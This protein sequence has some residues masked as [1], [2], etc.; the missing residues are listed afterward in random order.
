MEQPSGEAEVVLL[1][2]LGTEYY[3]LQ[4]LVDTGDSHIQKEMEISLQAG[5][6]VGAIYDAVLKQY[7][8]PNDPETLRSLNK[9]CVRLVFCLYAVEAGYLRAGKF[10]HY[11]SR[12]R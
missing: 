10:H 7:K 6:L 1:E 8:D 3:R 12:S 11:H 5:D 9:L 2:N 4:F